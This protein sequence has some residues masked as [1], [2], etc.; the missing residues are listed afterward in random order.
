MTS[1][2]LPNLI[3]QRRHAE[4]KGAQYANNVKK[5]FPIGLLWFASSPICERRVERS[6]EHS[7]KRARFKNV[8]GYNQDVL[9]NISYI[10]NNGC[11]CTVYDGVSTHFNVS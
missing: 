7:S 6:R 1:S 11:I 4:G 8:N 2:V 3:G 5:A 9:L 10:V